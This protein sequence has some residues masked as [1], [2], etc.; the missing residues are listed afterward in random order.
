[1]A[2]LRIQVLHRRSNWTME[3]IGIMERKQRND[4]KE[5]ETYWNYTRWQQALGKTTR[6]MQA[7]WVCIRITAG[8][9]LISAGESVWN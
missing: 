9:G 4:E 8:I 7:G 1:M 5:T 6:I 2:K 3:T